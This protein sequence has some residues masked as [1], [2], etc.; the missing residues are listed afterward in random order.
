MR[1]SFSKIPLRS[2]W[3]RQRLADL[4]ECAAYQAIARGVVTPRGSNLIV[5]FV[6]EE[7]PDDFTQYNDRLAGTRLHWEG[8]KEHW[9][10]RRIADAE[11]NGDEIHV[12]YRDLHRD[13]FTYLGRARLIRFEHKTTEPSR[14][15]FE[16]AG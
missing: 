12:F 1:I 10:D 5:L 3:T 14:A 9:T 11:K 7:K 16:L 2:K 4:W 8:E 15:E 6:Q 13:P